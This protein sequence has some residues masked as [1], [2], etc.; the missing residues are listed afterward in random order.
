M[1]IRFLKCAK[2]SVRTQES[3][4]ERRRTALKC[5]YGNATQT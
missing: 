2:A 1:E 3:S 4:K 5:R